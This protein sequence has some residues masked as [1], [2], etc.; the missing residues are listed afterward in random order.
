MTDTHNQHSGAHSHKH[1]PN[2]GHTAVKHDGH[3]D[4]LHD[5]HLHYT[6][7]DHVDDHRI[8]VSA[9]ILT[10][11]HRT[12]AAGRRMGSPTPTVSTAATKPYRMATTW[13]TWW[14]VICI[15]RTVLTATITASWKCGQGSHHNLLRRYRSSAHRPA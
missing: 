6:H 14:M 2:C 3:T 13:I 7:G 10:N 9:S 5:G 11:A 12:T 1:G 8:E 15:I 4:Y